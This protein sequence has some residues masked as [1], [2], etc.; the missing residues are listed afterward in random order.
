MSDEQSTSGIPTGPDPAVG[1]EAEAAAEATPGAGDAWRDVVAELDA[2]GDALGRWLKA[3]VNDPENKRR[4]EELSQRLNGFAS[5]VGDTVKGATDTE[6]GQSFKE[7]ADKTGEAF[8]VAGEKFSEEVGPKL[9]GAF[10]LM[11]EKLRGAADKIEERQGATTETAPPAA[12]PASAPEVPVAPE[13]PVTP[14][15]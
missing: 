8:K 3:A 13:P 5:E 14:H 6:V 2:L 9:A 10:K 7:A 4:L 12:G 1:A 15:D 11:G